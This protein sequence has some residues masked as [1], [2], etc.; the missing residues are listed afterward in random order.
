MADPKVKVGNVE[1]I[2]ISDADKKF[3]NNFG[4]FAV[5]ESNHGADGIMQRDEG[6]SQKFLLL[7]GMAHQC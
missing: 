1:I 2:S 7:Y 6:R 4:C 3:P 5:R